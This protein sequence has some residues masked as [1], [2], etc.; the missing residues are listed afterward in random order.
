MRPK[1]TLCNQA[2]TFL[3]VAELTMV[4]NSG[5]FKDAPPTRKPS[6][7]SCFASSAQL[8]PFT[9]PPYITRVFEATSVE[10]FVLSQSRTATCTS[11]ACWGVATLPVPIAQ[12]GSYAITILSQLGTASANAFNC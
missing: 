12:T 3:D 2:A 9:D 1:P 8:P 7:S 11:C 6:I 10:T 4:A 5:P